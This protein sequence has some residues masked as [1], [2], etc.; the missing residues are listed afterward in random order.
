MNGT[1]ELKPTPMGKPMLEHFMFEPGYRNMNHASYGAHPR[2]VHEAFVGFQNA[3]IAAPDR[4]IRYETADHLLAARKA[5]AQVV[6]ADVNDCV[7]VTNATLGINT[8]LRNLVFEPGD[9]VVYFSTIY[10]ACE[11]TLFSLA[12]TTPVE[13]VK[14]PLVYGQDPSTCSDS[15]ILSLFQ[16]AITSLHSAGK[17]VKVAMFDT[18]TSMPGVR[19]PFESL[20]SACRSHA[21]LSLI[22]AAHG[23]GHLPLDLP[24]LDPDFLISNCHKWLFVPRACALLYAASRAQ[25]LIRT[26]LPTSHGFVAP[27]RVLAGRGKASNPLPPPPPGMTPFVALFESFPTTD[28]TA[29]MCV[30][31]ALRF[32]SQVCGGEAAIHAYC[33]TLAR[34]GGDAAARILG[35]E[36]MDNAAGTLRADSVMANV[37]LPITTADIGVKEGDEQA[38]VRWLELRCL[39]EFK[40]SIQTYWHGGCWWTRLSAQVY[41]DVGDFEWAAEV[42]G[43]LCGEVRERGV[44]V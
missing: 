42:L 6:H 15:H 10:G 21:I 3:S 26:T 33:T 18:L 1:Q 13:L 32:R 7:F 40:A 25:H 37:R 23:I 27:A 38:L 9:V 14:L 24:H 43:G 34:L 19:M 8:V 31:A 36:V 41:L 16:A 4:F 12:E 22:D 39:E 11:Q 35:T 2:S 44:V 29:Y 5:V 17:T 20:T 28:V 30:P